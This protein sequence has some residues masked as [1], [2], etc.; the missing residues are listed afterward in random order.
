MPY[1]V[2]RKS[3]DKQLALVDSFE[4]YPPA[5]EACRRLRAEG[6]PDDPNAVRMIFAQSEHEARRLFSEKRQ[7]SSP[8]EEWEA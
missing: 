3:A 1:Y 2:F 6:S 7:P 8:L 4:K 5:K